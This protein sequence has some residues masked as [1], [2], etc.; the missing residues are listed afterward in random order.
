MDTYIQNP[1]GDGLRIPITEKEFEEVKQARAV[2]TAAL[3][4]EQCYDLLL[5]NYIELDK[6]LFSP[7][8]IQTTC[9]TMALQSTEFRR[10][11]AKS[12]QIPVGPQNGK[13]LSCYL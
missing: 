11:F 1:Y 4:M 12:G 10:V 7:A 2:L 8:V 9:N 5:G 13:F 6:E 3:A